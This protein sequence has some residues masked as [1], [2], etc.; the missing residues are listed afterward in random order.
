MDIK[1]KQHDI[2]DCGAA[3]LASV[4]AHYSLGVPIAKI[5]QWAGT[6]Q[7]GTNA[8]G[9]IKAAEKMS[10]N[11]KG[12]KAEVEA[13]QEIPL[14]AI[15]HV[16]VKKRL[17][18][19]V[20]IY[21]ISSSKITY[22][23][24]GDGRMHEKKLEHFCEEWTGVLILLSPSENFKE[25]DDRISNLSRFVYLLRPHRSV[26]LQ[27]LVGAIFFTI[28]GLAPSIYIQKITDYV[29][30]DGN[31]NLL[32]LMSVGMLLILL[33]KVVL[34][35]FQT[36]FILKTGQLIDARLILGY[37]KHL[38]RLPQS[39]FDTMR[40]GE[41]ISRINDAVKIR[42]FI[43]DSMISLIVNCFIVVFSFVLMFLYSWK[44]ALLMAVVIPFYALVYFITNRLNKKVERRV[45]EDAAEL[46][47]Q[48]VESL[49]AV[50][51]IKQFNLEEY[52]DVKT[53]VRFIQLLKT[54][55]KS[56]LNALFTG[57]SSHIISQIFTI[58]LLW[59]GSGLVIKQQITPGEL[60]S[61]YAIIGYFTG[62]VTSL[63]G[64]NKVIQNAAIAADRLFEIMDLERD[65]ENE[66]IELRKELIGDV[67]FE[68]V[69]FSYGTRVD[70]FENFCLKINRGEITAVIGE[71]G[72]GK[73]TLVALIQRLYP[74]T[75]GNI[76]I[77]DINL[78][79]ISKD[80]LRSMVSVVPQQLD[81]F[82]GNVIENIA[83]GDWRPSM[84][85]VINICRRLGILN[86]I[87]KLPNGFET[88]LG[89]NGATLSGGQKQRLAIAR[90]LYRDPE[91]L[92]MDEATSAL[93]SESEEYVQR[94][95]QDFVEEG[96]SV[97]IIAHRL[98][99]VA[100][101]NRLIVL[102]KGE[103]AEEGIPNELYARKGKYFQM[104]KK[105][106]PTVSFELSS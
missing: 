18:H 43:N 8:W 92:I 2:T 59:M 23:D 85:R 46:E 29:L 69:S 51:T 7:K 95:V 32:N 88:Y 62:P 58:A 12:V 19:Y 66:S 72:S 93:D 31:V 101:A 24:P 56:G 44:L 77:G 71:S 41:I 15:A 87:E 40:T 63:I 55:Y 37:Y 20:V 17:H 78:K 91:I 6:D 49:S 48:L 39:F 86:F 9:V 33:I 36:L 100:R 75:N 28:L 82:A 34:G 4:A 79:Y 54:A 102:E 73:I 103:V 70:V 74:L 84:E 16:I 45:M 50:R 64:M 38:L 105:Q 96:K 104:W 68:Q 83:V 3:C 27:A 98:G 57:Q 61:F 11:A 22:M 81:L 90:A 14:P 89:E 47:A 65:E 106:L 99:T 52:A 13:L 21:K 67:R 76:F 53:E 1:I 30:V 94:C 42:S 80:S 5:R 10:F 26:L 25:K 97:I 35:V 60:M